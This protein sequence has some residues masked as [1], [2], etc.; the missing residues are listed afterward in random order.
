[1]LKDIEE[2]RKMIKAVQEYQDP[3]A[4]KVA[5]REKRR[6]GE[7][8]DDTYDAAIERLARTS[9]EDTFIPPQGAH[10][11]IK[12]IAEHYYVPLLLSEDE[13]IDYIRHV[14]HVPSEVRFVKQLEEYLKK[15]DNQ[16]KSFSW[17]MFSRADETCDTIVIPYYDPTQN[18]MREFHP[19]FIFWLKRWNDYFILFVDPKGMQHTDYEHKIQ[20]YEEIFRDRETKQLRRFPYNGMNVRVALAMYT[21]DANKASPKFSDYWYDSPRGILK[22]LVA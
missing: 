19:D 7:I 20:G 15:E 21:S 8:D 6:I 2:L 11:K 5:L 4:Q 1:L 17:W 18:K 3:A 16:F 10:L 22:R 12:N 14:I 13:K 9:P